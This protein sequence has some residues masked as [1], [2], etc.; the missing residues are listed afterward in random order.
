MAAGEY[1]GNGEE[2]RA[3]DAGLKGFAQSGTLSEGRT[4]KGCPIGAALFCAFKSCGKMPPADQIR[5][6]L[7]WPNEPARCCIFSQRACGSDQCDCR[8]A[9][10]EDQAS[11]VMNRSAGDFEADVTFP[12]DPYAAAC[13]YFGVM[14][15]PEVGAGQPHGGGS[16]FAIALQKYQLWA[17]K[18]ARGQSY[19][20]EVL[21]DPKYT[22]P[23]RREFEGT[24]ERGR[25]RVFRRMAAYDIFGTQLINGFFKV[26]ALAAEAV[27]EGRADEVFHLTPDGQFGPVRPE[28]WDKAAPSPQQILRRT[29]DRW[30][31]KFA[32]NTT[33]NPA[34][35][36]QKAKDLNRRGFQTSI[37]VLHMAHGLN[38]AAHNAGPKINGWGERDPLLALILNAELWIWDAVDAAEEWRFLADFT[39]GFPYLRSDRMVALLRSVPAAVVSSDHA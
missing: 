24:L 8:T 19:L 12:H 2:A 14:A 7:D 11:K 26:R 18:R 15:Y 21:D 37:P 31:N 25:R 6:R 1:R 36:R 13:M 34:D 35:A 28:L 10:F 5:V 27:S 23:R 16:E 30:A 38:E 33:A 9:T 20:R 3:G 17:T 32:L 22:A 39:P 29:P 4:G